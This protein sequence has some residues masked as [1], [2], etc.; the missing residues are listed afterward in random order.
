M[1]SA[2]LRSLRSPLTSVKRRLLSVLRATADRYVRA[3][4][5]LGMI[6]R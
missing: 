6:D 1:L 5:Y 3:G 2:I 4:H